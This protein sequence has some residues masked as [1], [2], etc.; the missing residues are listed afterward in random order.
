MN[1]SKPT[2]ADEARAPITTA[3]SIDEARAF[4]RWLAN[5]SDGTEAEKDEFF[6]NLLVYAHFERDEEGNIL[7]ELDLPEEEEQTA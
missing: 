4:A 2:R 5:L 3:I 1:T 6:V 7:M